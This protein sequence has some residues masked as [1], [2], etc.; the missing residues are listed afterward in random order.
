MKIIF[1]A[2]INYMQ[3][4]EEYRVSQIVRTRGWE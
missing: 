3:R 2:I 4:L 1:T